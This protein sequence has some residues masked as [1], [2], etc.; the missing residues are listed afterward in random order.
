[1]D[2]LIRLFFLVVIPG[3]FSVII[4]YGLIKLLM[5]LKAM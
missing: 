4:V 3:S 1:M 2:K 5:N